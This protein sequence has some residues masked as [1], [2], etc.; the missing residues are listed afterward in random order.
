MRSGAD[1][2]PD[3]TE[4]TGDENHPALK[5]ISAKRPGRMSPDILPAVPNDFE[6]GP[7]RIFQRFDAVEALE[8]GLVDAL[9]LSREPDHVIAPRKAELYSCRFSP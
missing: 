8:A 1:H 4:G 7:D 5:A 3:V 2:D 6:A 9:L